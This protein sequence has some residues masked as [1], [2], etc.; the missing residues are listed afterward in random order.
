MFIKQKKLSNFGFLFY[1][2][3]KI[4]F[5]KIKILNLF[6]YVNLSL[7]SYAE[8]FDVS[9]IEKKNVVNNSNKVN[10]A[11]ESID[12]CLITGQQSLNA[13]KPDNE[14][15]PNGSPINSLIL[16][17]CWI[18]AGCHFRGTYSNILEHMKNSHSEVFTTV[19]IKNN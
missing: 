11:T 7:Q 2:I 6:K 4:I 3:F 5:H 18:G 17:S 19:S 12:V 16:Y 9:T 15:K 10:K 8:S 14:I 1:Y 13:K